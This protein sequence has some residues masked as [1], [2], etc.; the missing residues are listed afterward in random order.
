[1]ELIVDIGN[2]RVH[3]SLIEAGA[4][5]ESAAFPWRDAQLGAAIASA[6]APWPVA[7]RAAIF[8]VRPELEARVASELERLLGLIVEPIGSSPVENLTHAPSRVG[9]DRLMNATWAHYTRPGQAG[10][11]VSLGTAMTFDVVSE[12]GA[13]IG[14]AIAPGL[15]TGGRALARDTALLPEVRPTS[16]VAPLGR[17]TEAAISSGLF[18]GSVGAI[19]RLCE[20]L[21]CELK[22]P[23]V[24]A[25][26]GDAEALAPHCRMIQEVVSNLTSLG[27]WWTLTHRPPSRAAP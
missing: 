14:G 1:M 22:D 13:L 7:S 21:S 2:S 20:E 25:T 5:V 3:L 11:V 16:M 24:V 9:R 18:W 6:I 23:F 12:R 4:L 17:D 26:G 10:I 8:S 15:A 27:A 19:D